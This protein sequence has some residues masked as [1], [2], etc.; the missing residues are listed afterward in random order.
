[1]DSEQYEDCKHVFIS[2]HGGGVVCDKCGL[3]AEE[4]LEYG[5]EQTGSYS[6]MSGSKTSV[7]DNLESVPEEVKIIARSSMIKKGEFFVKKVRNDAKNTFKEVYVA[8]Q[9]TKIK[10][11]PN[12]LAEELGL[13]RKEINCCL[14]SLSGTSLTPSMH[15]DEEHFSMAILHPASTIH[16]ICI[17]NG[18][19]E[20][21]DKITELTREIVSRKQLYSAKPHHIGCAIV[22]KYCEAKGI[23]LKSFGKKNKL[24]DSALKKAIRRVEEFFE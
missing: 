15:D 21:S 17:K 12:E 24:S 23:P 20:H 16:K 22:K 5:Y 9:K 7:L 4:Q 10:F 6:S 11:D 13:S 3:M 1:M 18:L 2:N 14:K 8:Y 19:E